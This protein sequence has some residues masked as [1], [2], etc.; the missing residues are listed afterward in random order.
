MSKKKSIDLFKELAIEDGYR[1]AM[2]K[3]PASERITQTQWRNSI[4][5][6]V[7][8]DIHGKR[9]MTDQEILDSVSERELKRQIR[10]ELNTEEYTSAAERSRANLV[11]ALKGEF[12][13]EYKTLRSKLGQFESVKNN[14]S[15]NQNYGGYVFMGRYLID[16][17][18]SP[19]TVN[20]VEL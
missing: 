10:K 5:A 4:L 19:K 20:I 13:D 2:K 3:L 7:R 1:K 8:F 18:N 14:L 9:D 11:E 12:P 15:W 6:R 17:S 16:V